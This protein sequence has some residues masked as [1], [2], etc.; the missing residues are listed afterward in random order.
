MNKAIAT[1]EKLVQKQALSNNPKWADNDHDF[2]M[3]MGD[4]AFD[5]ANGDSKKVGDACNFY[6]SAIR[7][8][9]KAAEGYIKYAD[10]LLTVKRVNEAVTQL[11][12]L[13]K[14]SPNSRLRRVWTNTPS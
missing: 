13:L 12:A 5:A 8:N 7:V 2:Y 1:G 6:E 3:F 9:P 14:N 4:M 11:N 10:K